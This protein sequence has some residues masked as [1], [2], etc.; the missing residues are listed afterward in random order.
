MSTIR[1]ITFQ[2]AK[3][4]DVKRENA[5]IDGDTAMGTMLKYGSETAKDFYL[6]TLI[7]K[8]IAKAHI[9]G[10]IHIHDLDFYTLTL[11]LAVKLI[12]LSCSTTVF[13]LVMAS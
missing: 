8:D 4:S 6:S 7:D 12:Y 2:D 13:Q 11:L 5:N 10:D 3:D 9:S 1:S